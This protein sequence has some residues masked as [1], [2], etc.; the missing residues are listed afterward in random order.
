[1]RPPPR[2]RPEFIGAAI[3]VAVAALLSVPLG[4]CHF[5]GELAG[6]AAGGASAAASANPAVGIAVG[7][8]VN[9]G[10]DATTDY[11]V[12]VRQRAEQDAIVAQVATMDVGDSRTW[13]IEHTIPI[14]NEHGEVRVSRMIATPLTLCKELVFSVESGGGET[15]KQRWYSTEACQSGQRWKWSLAEPA[16]ER[17]GSLQ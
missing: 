5:I 4:G 2:R 11:I 14:G 7:V 9:S 3:G 12:R 8:A 13:K 15:L 6:A 10:V 16:V 1:M 17:W